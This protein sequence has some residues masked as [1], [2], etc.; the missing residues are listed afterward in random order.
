MKKIEIIKYKYAEKKYWH[1]WRYIP[2]GF[3]RELKLG[4]KKYT[5]LF[6]WKGIFLNKIN[7]LFLG[8][9]DNDVYLRSIYIE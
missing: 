4:S 7:E 3:K 6:G 1:I 2:N 8:K 5:Y 9:H